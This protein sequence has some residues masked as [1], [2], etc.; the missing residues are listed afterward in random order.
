MQVV[1]QFRSSCS[2]KKKKK[3]GSLSNLWQSGIWGY[4]YL[5]ALEF[6]TYANCPL[7]QW[8]LSIKLLQ[9]HIQMKET[10]ENN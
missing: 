2:K 5:F 4:F 6:Y 10:S 9:D 3:D 1:L 8:T 7:K